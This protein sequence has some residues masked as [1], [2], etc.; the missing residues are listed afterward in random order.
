MGIMIVRFSDQGADY[1]GRIVGNAPASRQASIHV[2]PIQTRAETTS[3]LIAALGSDPPPGDAGSPIRISGAQLRCPITTDA[4]LLCQGLNYRDHAAEAGHQERKPNLLFMKASSSLSGPYD[5][6]RRPRNVELLD[7]EAEIGIVLRANLCAPELMTDSN[8]GDFV[9]G[10]VLCN[11]VSARD[12]MFGASFF[13][14]FEG[15]SARTF[16]PAGPVLYFLEP[17]EVANTLDKLQLKLWLNGELRQSGTSSQL[18]YQPA[19]TLTHVAG[20]MDLRR[21]DVLLTGTPGGV[22]AQGSPRLFEI[23]K[24]NL[25]ADLARRDAMRA[26][27]L[28]DARFLIPGDRITINLLDLNTGLDLGGQ[29]TVIVQ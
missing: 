23:L 8:V 20:F 14:W 6:I 9:A 27:L 4:Q 28:A 12:T 24:D 26:E 11:D 22:I 16:C 7:Y 13:Q 17:S 29:D 2:V 15:K 5:P 25:H 21:G 18:I 19:E 10:V 1:W 3:D